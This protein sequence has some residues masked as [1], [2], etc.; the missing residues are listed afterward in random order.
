M[1]YIEELEKQNEELKETLAKSQYEALCLI[2]RMTILDNIDPF[3]LFISKM[4]D[5]LSYRITMKIMFKKVITDTTQLSSDKAIEITD[6]IM[7]YV[8]NQGK[9]AQ[10]H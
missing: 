1:N 6:A 5:N 3:D 2:E 4:S 9:D 7:Y 10:L 8:F